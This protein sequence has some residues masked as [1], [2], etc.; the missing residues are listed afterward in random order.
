MCFINGSD[1]CL[2]KF[3]LIQEELVSNPFVLLNDFKI[4]MLKSNPRKIE[5][6]Q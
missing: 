4:N 3:F 1:T 6:R 2:L 5:F